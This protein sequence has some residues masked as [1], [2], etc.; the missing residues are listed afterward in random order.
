MANEGFDRAILGRNVQNLLFH[1]R[2]VLLML[3]GHASTLL[4]FTQQ[5]SLRKCMGAK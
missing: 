2:L 1:D 5:Q 3:C 4:G